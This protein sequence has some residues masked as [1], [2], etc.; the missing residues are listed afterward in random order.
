MSTVLKEITEQNEMESNQVNNDG[1]VN[2]QKEKP[3]DIDS[4]VKSENLVKHV[5]LTLIAKIT[6]LK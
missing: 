6:Y 4:R 3:K 2:I 5:N 1:Y